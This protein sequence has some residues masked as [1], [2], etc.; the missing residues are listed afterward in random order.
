MSTL[1]LLIVDVVS[2]GVLDITHNG[3][4]IFSSLPV[5]TA[6]DPATCA[7][8]INVA[9][10]NTDIASKTFSFPL[11]LLAGVAVVYAA[12]S[13]AAADAITASVD[14]VTGKQLAVRVVS[15]DYHP[16]GGPTRE[17]L[18]LEQITALS[19]AIAASLNSRY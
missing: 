10:L 1:N 18:A 12:T 17:V 16:V 6:Q 2:G 15:S 4:S 5:L 13:A 7:S 3:V 14:G 9:G 11:P 8:A 19:T